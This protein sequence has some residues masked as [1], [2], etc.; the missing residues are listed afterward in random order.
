MYKLKQFVNYSCLNLVLFRFKN[1]LSCW[2][3]KFTRSH[4]AF[5]VCT[6][7]YHLR[8]S[9]DCFYSAVDIYPLFQQTQRYS[10]EFL[11]FSIRVLAYITPI[12]DEIASLSFLFFSADGLISAS[13]LFEWS[14]YGCCIVSL[15]A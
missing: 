11:L 4:F 15:V 12:H 1:I 13:L 7:V 8:L 9:V 3:S 2:L 14:V 5:S 6:C 10:D